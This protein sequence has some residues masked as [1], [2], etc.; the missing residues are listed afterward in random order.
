MATI[1]A[2]RPNGARSSAVGVDGRRT[3]TRRCIASGVLLDKSELLRF[4]VGP[5]GRVVPDI[6]GKLP[7]RGLW[8]MPRRD[9]I[10]KACRRNLFARAARAP[11]GVPGD[12]VEQV[13]RALRRRCLDLIGLARRAGLVTAGYQKARSRLAAGKAAVLV[14][15]RDAALGGREKLTALARASG[16]AGPVVEVFGAEELG[17][18]LGRDSAVHVVLAPGALTDRFTAEVARLDAVA[19]PDTTQIG[20]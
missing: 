6:G 7:G 13:T 12:L 17:Q 9:M 11:V 15:A 5:D 16:L 19:G 4:V 20:T 18:V 14:Q 8:L 1:L 10:E 2:Q 3:A